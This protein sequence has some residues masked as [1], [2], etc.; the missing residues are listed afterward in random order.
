MEKKIMAVFAAVLVSFSTHEKTGNFNVAKIRENLFL[1][2]AKALIKENEGLKLRAYFDET[3][4]S[5]GYGTKSFAGEEI[6]AQEAGKR[7]EA[8]FLEMVQQM[9]W[10]K[11]VEN[12]AVKIALLDLSYQRG[13]VP[14]AI[15][16]AAL[17]GNTG[18]VAKL[19]GALPASKGVKNRYRRLC[20]LLIK[21]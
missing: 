9:G 4:H 8:Y 15:K 2:K 12:E 3:R 14:K 5:I 1:Q 19:I 16:L 21:E 20:R 6:T 13:N 17:S 18:E 7:F 11:G 10:I